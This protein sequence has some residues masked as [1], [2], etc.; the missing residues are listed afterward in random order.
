M[1]TTR[2]PQDPDEA[3]GPARDDVRQKRVL[4][5]LFVLVPALLLLSLVLIAVRQ[6]DEVNPFWERT[7]EFREVHAL[8][9]IIHARQLTDDEFARALQL[10]E[11]GN[12]R[13]RVDAVS[14]VEESVKRNPARGEAAAQVMRRVVRARNAMLKDAAQRL[15]AR[16]ET[17]PAPAPK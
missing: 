12:V 3:H 7:P 6:W 16:I 4:R 9:P 15:L 8:V 1:T 11:S 17:P 5:W 2:S 10:C 13:V 14:L